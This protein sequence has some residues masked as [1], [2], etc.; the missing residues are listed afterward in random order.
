MRDKEVVAIDP[1][2]I[3]TVRTSVE[4][5]LGVPA[6]KPFT[7][8]DEFPE[9]W[10]AALELH[11][12]DLALRIASELPVGSFG[13]ASYAFASAATIG[14]ALHAFRRDSQ[15]TVTGITIEL[16]ITGEDAELSMIGPE[17]V[18]P[19]FEILLGIIALR[20]Q[21]LP[22]SPLSITRVV[23]PRP[24]PADVTPWLRLFTVLPEFGAKRALLVIPA[25]MLTSPL[26]TADAG[27]RE[28]LGSGPILTTTDEVRAHV[29]QWIREAPE[30]EE[31]A[32]A[33]GLSVRTLQRRLT[34]EGASFR[35]IVLAVKVDVAKDLLERDDLTI[36][37][38]ASAV[39]FARVPAFSRAFSQ[40]TGISPSAFRAQR[41]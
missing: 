21:Q 14:D 10:R 9:Y 1:A 38:V 6:P 31:V 37:E 33:L 28:A 32:R 18:W 23:L 15:R 17:L 16:A 2:G 40:R 24:Q 35:D 26:R 12:E 8:A 7:C 11:G 39:G 30:A 4:R 3:A 34:E 36:A 27:V 22:A 25:A 29:R 20:C 19:L 13:R 5:V 41:K